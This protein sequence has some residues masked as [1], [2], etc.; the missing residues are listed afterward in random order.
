MVSNKAGNR[1][2]PALRA[3]HKVQVLH[4]DQ[5]AEA[6][7]YEEA[8]TT[9][10]DSHSRSSPRSDASEIAHRA[11]LQ[12]Q[13]TSEAILAEA[14]AA[15]PSSSPAS[16][17]WDEVEAFDLHGIHVADAN[18]N[19][20]DANGDSPNSPSTLTLTTGSSE[21]GAPPPGLAGGGVVTDL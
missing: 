21:E 20:G 9:A 2:A 4:I 19:D 17:S 5:E 13:Q 11:R 1:P 16:P 14:E 12:L 7:A 6:R 3:S 10:R 8:R 18:V 15:E